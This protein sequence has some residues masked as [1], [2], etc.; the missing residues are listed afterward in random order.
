MLY[1]YPQLSESV[2]GTGSHCPIPAMT[3][4]DVHGRLGNWQ[5][6]EE[7]A[8]ATS[9]QAYEVAWPVYF[10]ARSLSSKQPHP[11]QQLGRLL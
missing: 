9:A 5:L 2:T 8:L 10:A 11:K 4:L 7:I 6:G 1:E 3:Q